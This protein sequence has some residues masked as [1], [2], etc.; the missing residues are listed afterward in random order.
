MLA[1]RSKVL[2]VARVAVMMGL[3]SLTYS[4]VAKYANVCKSGGREHC[5][6]SRLMRCRVG[7]GYASCVL[8]PEELSSHWYPVEI[9]RRVWAF[10]S[11]RKT[12]FRYTQASSLLLPSSVSPPGHIRTVFRLPT[13]QIMLTVGYP[14]SSLS[15]VLVASRDWYRNIVAK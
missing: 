13:T 5:G 12:C 8:I 11:P 1:Q 15:T 14:G 3:L 2:G 9:S 4:A 6:R 10:R 7:H